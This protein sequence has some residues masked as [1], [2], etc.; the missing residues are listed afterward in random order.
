MGAQPEVTLGVIP[1]LGG[2]Q[3]LTRAV[4]KA[5]AMEIVLGGARRGAAPRGRSCAGAGRAAHARGPQL[6]R[7]WLHPCVCVP[8]ASPDAGAACIKVKA[9]S[10]PLGMGNQRAARLRLP[11]TARCTQ[12]RQPARQDMPLLF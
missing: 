2:T 8:V 9:L 3:R 10:S 1:G 4:G 7:M 5:K 6:W 11:H 12:A